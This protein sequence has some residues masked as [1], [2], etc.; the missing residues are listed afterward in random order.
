MDY[1]KAYKA[2]LQTATQWIKDG[3]TDKEKICLKCVFPELRESEDERIRKELIE[4]LRGDLDDITTDDTDRWISWLQSLRPQPHWKPSEE[5]MEALML[6]IEG[7]CL[8]TSYM[9]RRLE[10]LYDGLANTYR[11]DAKLD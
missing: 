9:S 6:A 11:I 1:E 4:Y 2:V 7:K 8:P 10:D 5:Q 3:C